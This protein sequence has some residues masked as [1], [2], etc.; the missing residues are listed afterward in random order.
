MGVAAAHLLS[1]DFMQAR[2]S[3]GEALTAFASR[4]SAAGFRL[5]RSFCDELARRGH[6]AA[7]SSLGE[8]IRAMTAGPT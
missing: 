1:G 7:A 2:E 3:A 5:V 8:Q 4:G 6:R